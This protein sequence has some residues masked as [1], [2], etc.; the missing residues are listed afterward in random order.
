MTDENEID[1]PPNTEVV[2]WDELGQQGAT[3]EHIPAETESSGKLRAAVLG[4]GVLADSQRIMFDTK[5]ADVFTCSG[6]EELDQIIEYKPQVVFVCV[7][8]PFL[9]NDSVDD[10]EF[11]SCIKRL[12]TETKAGVC[13]KTTLNVETC[14]RVAAATGAE[15]FM[16]K[17]VYSPELGETVDEILGG[18]TLLVGAGEKPGQGHMK[19]VTTGTY[20]MQK[21]VLTGTVNEIV[22]A[23]LGLVGYKAVKQTFFNQFH[24]AVLDIEGANPAIVRRLIMSLLPGE[25]D[26]HLMIPTFVRAQADETLTMKQAR[27]FGGEFANRD[28]KFLTS[29]TDRLTVLDECINLRNLKD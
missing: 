22:F 4:S 20:N 14:D 15:W 13:V 18:D 12:A 19:I 25:T 26:R 27:A 28:A 7:D 5:L 29:M 11:L 3:L 9:K 1:L 8:L 2:S 16:N 24:Q 21:T 6:F 17:F 23:K 10:T